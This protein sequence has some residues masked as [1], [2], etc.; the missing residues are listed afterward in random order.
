MTIHTNTID[1]QI[2]QGGGVLLDQRKYSE[3]SENIIIIQKY[4]ICSHLAVAE[5]VLMMFCIRPMYSKQVYAIRTPF[6][7][8]SVF[9]LTAL[10]KLEIIVFSGFHCKLIQGH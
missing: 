7:F 5:Y 3:K 9:R 2:T 4:I 8:I 1:F 10:L 6:G